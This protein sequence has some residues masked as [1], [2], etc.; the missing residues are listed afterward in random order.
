[1]LKW[2]SFNERI[3]P[4]MP[5]EYTVTSCLLLLVLV[6][7]SGCTVTGGVTAPSSFNS[8]SS[9]AE[10]GWALEARICQEEH[11]PS[12]DTQRSS[13]ELEL[14]MCHLTLRVGCSWVM[15]LCIL[16]ATVNEYVRKQSAQTFV[17]RYSQQYPGLTI[18]FASS[19]SW[20]RSAK[21]EPVCPTVKK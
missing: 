5:G 17:S 14:G 6:S 18:C 16:E 1:M 7:P 13:L 19:W 15:S 9:E 3:C 2:Q 11:H 12:R 21:P 4:F 20:Y 10:G 8:E